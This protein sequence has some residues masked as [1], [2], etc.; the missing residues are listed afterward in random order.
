MLTAKVVA[1]GTVVRVELPDGSTVADAAREAR[2]DESL[3]CEYRG[4]RIQPANRAQHEVTDG[5]TLIFTAPALKH[6]R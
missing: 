1:L 3:V 6:G 4:Q 5:A 2:V